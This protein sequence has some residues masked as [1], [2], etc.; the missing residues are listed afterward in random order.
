MYNAQFVI[1]KRG[2]GIR[3]FVNQGPVHQATREV[4]Y[5]VVFFAALREK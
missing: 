1:E 5:A 4:V 3:K 2:V